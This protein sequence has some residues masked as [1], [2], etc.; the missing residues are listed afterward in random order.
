LVYSAEGLPEGATLEGTKFSWTPN[1]DQSGTYD[2]KFILS[3]AALQATKNATI[4]VNHVNRPPVLD[5][6]A[7]QSVN[8]NAEISFVLNGSD[9]DKEDAGKFVL[10][11][12]NL[13]TGAVFDPL[14]GT[15][16]WT[17]TFDQSGEYK[18]AFTNSDPQSLTDQKEAAITVNHTNRT[19]VLADILAKTVAEN[20]AVTFDL[21]G[22]D[23]DVEDTGKLVYSAEGLPEG[24]TLVGTK[25]SWTPG[26]DQSGNYEVKLTVLDGTLQATK[27]ATIAVTH[28]N[29]TLVFGELAKQSV[30]E[31]SALSFSLNV[32]DPDK[33]DQGK[34]KYITEGL[35][36]GAVF[37]EAS[38][39]LSWTPNYDQS[40]E[41][42][43]SFTVS[44]QEF[45]LKQTVG[46]T[47]SHVNRAPEIA[48]I[49][50]Q[51]VAETKS[52]NVS[53]S[54]SDADKEDS[55]KLTVS[56]TGLPAGALFDATT[57]V[58]SWT[59]TYEQAGSFDGISVTATDPSG[60]KAEEVIEITVTNENR[61][62]EIS[63]P[64]SA[65]VEAG[66]NLSLSYSSSDP[67]KD[68]LSYSLDGAPSGMTIDDNGSISWVP[69]DDQ[70]GSHTLNVI[71]SDG[72]SKVSTPLGVSVSA[73]PVPVQAPAPIDTTGNKSQ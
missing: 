19:P 64:S 15:F 32:S 45:S 51:T 46:I 49:G 21:E 48:G 1:Y 53:I 31:N 11:A 67:D 22:S 52:L 50:N 6:I 33:E 69:R 37:D 70:V 2:V 5:D 54:A 7:K 36:D 14:T 61:D 8:E 30:N 63:G 20:A 35:P 10:S 26:Y 68:D 72:I 17:P 56:V 43:V 27:N 42:M 16:S 58:I 23:P 60:L 65:E 59:P 41:Y 13:P 44:D 4:T 57:N 47:V 9:P 25:F 66:S 71:V 39:T 55:G 73:K 62:P 24:A 40:G 34:L 18:V 3:D 38:Q 12:T 28:V 29:R